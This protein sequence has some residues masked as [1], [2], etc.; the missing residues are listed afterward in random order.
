M[1][2]ENC[3]RLLKHYSNI[4]D[5]TIPSP[6]GHKNWHDVVKHA[7]TQAELMKERIAIRE[8]LMPKPQTTKKKTVE[9]V[10]EQK[11]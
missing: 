9:K 8:S 4:A 2:L 1:T 3:K 7:K 5:G 10:E 11:E 6:I